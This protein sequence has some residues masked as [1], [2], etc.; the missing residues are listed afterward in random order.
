MSIFS[1]DSSNFLE[2]LRDEISE[3]RDEVA[4]V[5]RKRGLFGK[6]PT[7]TDKAADGWHQSRDFVRDQAQVVAKTAREHP[8]GLSVG[9]ILILGAAAYGIYTMMNREDE[10]DTVGVPE[11]A[12]DLKF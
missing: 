4:K 1:K 9:S 10:V 2:S 5:A 7:F 12:T 11:S 3:L 8:T 6:E